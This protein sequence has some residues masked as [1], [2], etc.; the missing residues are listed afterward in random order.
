M[1]K[2]AGEYI[3]SL[4]HW[5]WI[6]LVGVLQAIW[7]L[8]SPIFGINYSPVIWITLL[9]LTLMIAPFIAFH[10][11]RLDRDDLREKLKSKPVLVLRGK[12]STLLTD[13]SKQAFPRMIEFYYDV[14]IANGSSERSLGI[15]EIVLQLSHTAFASPY[16]GIPHSDFGEPEEGTISGSITLAPNGSQ[17]GKLAFLYE[18]EK[19]EQLDWESFYILMR[20]TQKNPHIFS[21]SIKEMVDDRKWVKSINAK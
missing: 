9:F 1:W 5:G 8:V 19:G 11:M 16:V 2:S 18:L 17:E 6:V 15:I 20:D 13:I 14:Q 21:A 3:S 7:G 12:G 4:G 10:K